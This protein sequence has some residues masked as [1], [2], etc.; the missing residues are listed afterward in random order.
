MEKTH[1]TVKER[2]LYFSLGAI[3]L[4]LSSL[5]M[6]AASDYVNNNNATLNFGR[7]AI[8]SWA[9]QVDGKSGVVGAFVLDTVS[10]ETRTVYIRTYGD[11]PKSEA[12]KNDLKKPFNAIQ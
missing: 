9:T 6:G 7:Y 1:T 4:A 11:V 3:C 5:L 8:S 12:V 2:L 10:G